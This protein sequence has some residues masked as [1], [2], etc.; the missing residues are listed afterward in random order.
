MSQEV[1][2]CHRGNFSLFP[3]AAF[4]LDPGYLNVGLNLQNY[5]LTIKV[6]MEEVFQPDCCEIYKAYGK[7]EHIN[8]IAKKSGIDIKVPQQYLQNKHMITPQII[9]HAFLGH[10]LFRQP[11][12]Q[13]IMRGRDEG[14]HCGVHSRRGH[15]RTLWGEM[16]LK[17]DADHPTNVAGRTVSFSCSRESGRSHII[18]M[19]RS[20]ADIIK[21]ELFPVLVVL[22]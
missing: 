6:T 14:S 4:T 11:N 22:L 16:S 9:N 10:D 21:F 1:P 13:H 3:E 20:L 18:T 7:N 2:H 15:S 17:L 5:C 8:A 12:K 19:V